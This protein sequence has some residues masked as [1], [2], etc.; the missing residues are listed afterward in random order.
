[1]VN[2]S[3]LCFHIKPPEFL[4]RVTVINDVSASYARCKQY[5]HSALIFCR[6]CGSRFKCLY[7][8]NFCARHLTKEFQ[9]R[10]HAMF[11]TH[12]T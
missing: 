4:D 12:T 9:H 1:M 2:G 6:A 10:S 3:V 8:S 5:T 7:C 11:R